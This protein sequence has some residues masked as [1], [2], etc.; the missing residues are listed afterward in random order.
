LRS[1][2]TLF[3]QIGE[4]LFLF[5]R[6]SLHLTDCAAATNVPGLTVSWAQAFDN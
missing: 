4:S 1:S 3:L 2:S 6:I 5:E